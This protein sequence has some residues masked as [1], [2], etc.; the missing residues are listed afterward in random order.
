MS[1][2]ERDKLPPPAGPFKLKPFV[3]ND[4]A[5]GPTEDNDDNEP[6]FNG[7]IVK[8]GRSNVAGLLG[9]LKPGGGPCIWAGISLLSF[10]DV[11][12]SSIAR[13]WRD[14]FTECS[15]GSCRLNY[16]Q[17][18]FHFYWNLLLRNAKVHP[19]RLVG[20]EHVIETVCL[21]AEMSHS[22]QYFSLIRLTSLHSE[23]QL[24]DTS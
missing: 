22:G 19:S 10:S 16:Y 6:A 7:G 9:R 18:N 5:E 3:P 13:D 8:L 11:F 23:N 24:S 12:C 15:R 2:D 1:D 17:M 4:D 20:I 21:S 14:D